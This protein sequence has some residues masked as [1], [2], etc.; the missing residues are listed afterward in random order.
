MAKEWILNM[1]TN[2]WGLNKKTSVGPVSQWIRECSPK[3][4]QDWKGFYLKKLEEM[5]KNR[6]SPFSAQQYLNDLG[7]KLFVKITEVLEAEIKEVTEVDC[8]QYIQNLVFDRTFDGYQTEI[9]T[10][11]GKLQHEL[12]L[13]I[14]PAPDDWDRTY[15][16][17]FFIEVGNKYIG[18]QIKPITYE[19]TPEIHKW[20]EWLEK[21][22]K[23]FEK[24]KG[25]RVFVIFSTA[26]DRI[27]SI[28]NPE[29]IDEIRLEIDR[30]S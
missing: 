30:L 3:E 8:I 5:L 10:I 9:S 24:E 17:D 19:H 14:K 15:N 20:L 12:N 29:V 16:V 18:I 4:L 6:K 21:T 23:K 26:K 13:P 28:V 27:K 11:H 2:R 7:C 1:A 22:H 25:G